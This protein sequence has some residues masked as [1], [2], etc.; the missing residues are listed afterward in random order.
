MQINLTRFPVDMVR[1][2]YEVGGV[3]GRLPDRMR[4]L[5]S[6]PCA[7]S[8]ARDLAHVVVVSDMFRSP[9]SSLAA[10]QKKR[11]VQPPSFSHHN[12]GR[13]I[14]LDVRESYKQSGCRSKRELDLLMAERGWYCYRGDHGTGRTAQHPYDESW[15]F[16]F[17]GDVPVELRPQY[18]YRNDRSI[19]WAACRARYGVGWRMRTRHLASRIGPE[20]DQAVREC[21]LQLRDRGFYHGAVDGIP[22]PQTRAAVGALQRAWRLPETG[23]LDPGTVQVLDYVCADITIADMAEAPAQGS[24]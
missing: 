22:G 12:Y 10:M 1:G 21:Q 19:A 2:I 13:A 20:F 14:D 4:V 6:G 16:D 23:K 3:D 11:G 8:F 18:P 24:N 9:E 5:E 15:H 17:L 7:G